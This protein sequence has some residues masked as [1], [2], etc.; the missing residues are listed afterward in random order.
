MIF[1]SASNWLW[2]D[3]VSCTSCPDLPRFDESESESYEKVVDNVRTLTY[4]LGARV[5]GF[6]STDTI[7]LTMD[8]CSEEFKFVTV[9]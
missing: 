8:K 4:G 5:T 9:I 7:C 2:V 3:S 6:I 1:D